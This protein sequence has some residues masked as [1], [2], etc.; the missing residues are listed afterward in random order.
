[1]SSVGNQDLL[2]TM[3]FN[4]NTYG[5]DSWGAL[6]DL[7]IPY[8]FG[9]LCGFPSNPSHHPKGTVLFLI[10]DTL[11]TSQHTVDARKQT[12]GNKCEAYATDQGLAVFALCRCIS[13]QMGLDKLFINTLPFPVARFS[14]GRLNTRVYP[15]VLLRGI[16][17]PGS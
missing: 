3:A 10:K 12:W 4:L 8:N 15:C 11:R 2:Q 1:M 7:G 6:S 17:G 14:L 16:D 9:C 5:D 13:C